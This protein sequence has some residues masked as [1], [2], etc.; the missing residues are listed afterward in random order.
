MIVESM[1]R[2]IKA[3][4]KAKGDPTRYYEVAD[5]FPSCEIELMVRRGTTVKRVPQQSVTVRCP[6][7]HCGKSL[8]ITWCKLGTNNWERINTTQN[9]QITQDDVRNEMISYLTFK[10][11]SVY[12]DGLYRCELK[13]DK[14]LYSHAI[15][16]SV[17]DMHQGADTADDTQIST[18]VPLSAARGEALSW[19]PYLYICVGIALLVVTMILLTLLRFNGHKS[20]TETLTFQPTKRQEMSSHTIPDLPKGSAPSTPVLQA[21]FVLNEIYSPST[22]RTPPLPLSLITDRNLPLA[23]TG[24]E[25]QGSDS[26]VYAV[27]NHTQC[28]TTAR[29]QRAASRQDKSPEYATVNVS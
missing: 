17:S 2:R 16:I 19:L 12:D 29:K 27:I 11:I 6:V 13:G 7:K 10:W 22:A 28:G 24:D 23:N 20:F 25:S 8:N 15:N 14:Y 26:A 1:P 21:H 4:L 3:A 5:S 9:V 18:V